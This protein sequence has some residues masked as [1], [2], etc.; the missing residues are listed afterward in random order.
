MNEVQTIAERYEEVGVYTQPN[1]YSS[2]NRGYEYRNIPVYRD[3][4]NAE[5]LDGIAGQNDVRA[6]KM[7]VE[8]VNDGMLDI[9]IKTTIQALKLWEYPWFIKCKNYLYVIIRCKEVRSRALIP[10]LEYAELI[11]SDTFSLPSTSKHPAKFHFN[12]FPVISP[13]YIDFAVLYDFVDTANGF[14]SQARSPKKETAEGGGSK[15][16]NELLQYLGLFGSKRY[17][18]KREA[19][20]VGLTVEQYREYDKKRLKLLAKYKKHLAWKA[21]VDEFLRK[22]EIAIFIIIVIAIALF[23]FS[24]IC[25]QIPNTGHYM[26]LRPDRF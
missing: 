5:F 3:W 4:D 16:P 11:W 14:I 1:S 18:E 9:L 23:I 12:G 21:K 19:K 25:S 13:K 8:D 20:A 6:I 2:A 24:S 7:N 17:V 22:V 26:R 10:Y 15:K